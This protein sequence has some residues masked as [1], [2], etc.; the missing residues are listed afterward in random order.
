M[1]RSYSGLVLGFVQCDPKGQNYEP[2]YRRSWHKSV[3]PAM[4]VVSHL[5]SLPNDASGLTSSA[6]RP[7]KL[8]CM[9]LFDNLLCCHISQKGTVALPCTSSEDCS[10]WTLTT[11][12]VTSSLSRLLGF[13]FCCVLILGMLVC[14]EVHHLRSLHGRIPTSEILQLNHCLLLAVRT[15]E[16]HARMSVLD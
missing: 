2:I 7:T 16:R 13:C 1:H 15:N 10:V 12:A 11:E 14:S 9:Q 6:F 3:S 4:R 5:Q 8:C